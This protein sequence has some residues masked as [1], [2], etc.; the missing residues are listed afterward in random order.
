MEK[1]DLK[2]VHRAEYAPKNRSWE[3]IDVPPAQYLMI[4]GAGDPNTSPLYKTAVEALYSVS[5]AIKFL[6]KAEQRDFVVMP[7]EGLWHAADYGVFT[8]AEKDSFRWT[9]MIRQP[10]WIGQEE[11]QEGIDK[12]AKKCEFPDIRLATLS[13]GLC[14]QVLHIGSYDEEAPLLAQLHDEWMPERGLKFN[15]LHHEIY[16]SDPRRVGPERLKT[17]LRQPVSEYSPT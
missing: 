13:E 5:Y 11:L 14:A 7:L 8:R 16:L 6:S 12:A 3:L 15:G 2:K 10:E 4:D 1:T 9:M 17:V